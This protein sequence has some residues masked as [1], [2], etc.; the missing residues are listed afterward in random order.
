MKTR[1]ISAII[2]LLILCPIIYYGNLAFDIA[3]GL[4]SMLALKELLDAKEEKKLLPTFV[5]AISYLIMI[6]I[7]FGTKTFENN[8]FSIDFRLISGLFLIFFVPTILYHNSKFYS[9]NDACFLIAEVLFLGLAFS[10]LIIIRNM[11]LKI[12]IYLVLITTMTDTY[13]LFGGKLIG[14]HPLVK[15]ISPN[16][17][18]EG[19]IIGTVFAVFVSSLFYHT[20]INPDLEVLNICLISLFLSIIGQ[21]GDLVFSSI[22]RY[23]NKKDFSNLIPGHGGILD[24]LDSIIFVSVAFMFV[25]SFI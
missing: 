17:T 25:C 8:N 10:S 6:F 5:K 23:Y 18:W 22:K 7:T 12:F 11:D 9:I 1:I 4:V 16:K 15:D 21:F 2:L 24:R 13:A 3:V 14:K 20:M 19:T